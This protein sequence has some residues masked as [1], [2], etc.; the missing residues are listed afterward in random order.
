MRSS[1]GLWHFCELGDVA[2]PDV[3]VSVMR[4]RTSCFASLPSRGPNVGGYQPLGFFN[5][6]LPCSTYRCC[7]NAWRVRPYR[8][9]FTSLRPRAKIRAWG[10]CLSSDFAQLYTHFPT[11]L[12]AQITDV[13]AL[14]PWFSALGQLFFPANAP[15]H[16]CLPPDTR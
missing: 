9:P 7:P 13:L 2:S 11:F 16:S 4:S 8:R 1:E 14:A 6:A 12:R 15:A 5:Q 10:I 3:K